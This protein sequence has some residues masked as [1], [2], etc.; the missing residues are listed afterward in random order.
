MQ[1]GQLVAACHPSGTSNKHATRTC[2]SSNSAALT[3]RRAA[4]FIERITQLR[5]EPG[6]EA[7]TD[8]HMAVILKAMLV[9]GASWNDWYPVFDRI[10]DDRDTGPE[11]WWRI[12]R[13]CARFLGYG[14]VDFDR[15]S[16]CT[17]QRAIV[18]GC[19]EL[20]AEEG[21]LYTVPLPQALNA[22]TVSRRLTITLAWLSPINPRHRSYRVADLWFDPTAT[23]LRVK[24]REVDHDSVTRGTVQ[25]EVLEGDDAV[26]ITDDTTIEVQVNC[27]ADAGAKLT[28]PVPYALLVTLETALPLGVSI[29]E[30]IK[31]KLDALRAPVS[32]RS[33][34]AVLPRA[35]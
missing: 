10:F 33:T 19:G 9:H 30:Q 25:H 34:T 31:L 26:P 16:I 5:A 24:R 11:R 17:D 1:P 32:I 23:E 2:G 35:R 22:Q 6:G 4:Q 3:T 7:L 18:L 29:Y 21:H 15:G 20:R 28:Q 12:K 8:A 27:R 13:A 14:P